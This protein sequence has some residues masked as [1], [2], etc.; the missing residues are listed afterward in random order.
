[1]ILCADARKIPLASDTA[2]TVVT[3]P[4]YWGLRDYGL[5][6]SVW[7]A[8]RRPLRSQPGKRRRA[9]ACSHEWGIGEL[10]GEAYR[11]KKRWQH[12]GS[13]QTLRGVGE[14]SSGMVAAGNFWEL[15]A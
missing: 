14:L 13:G 12:V 10:T 4:P 15:Y 8:A 7:D 9:V 1:M 3:S 6:P 5:P 11:G 2:Q